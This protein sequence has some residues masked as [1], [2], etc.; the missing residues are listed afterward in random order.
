MPTTPASASTSDA[1]GAAFTIF[2]HL[3]ASCKDPIF[4]EKNI[5]S[6]WD[7]GILGCSTKLVKC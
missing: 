6:P 4:S 7:F 5:L 3:L 2:Q 1:S